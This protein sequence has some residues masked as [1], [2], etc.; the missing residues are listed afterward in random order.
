MV[1]KVQVFEVK[2]SPK[3]VKKGGGG[4]QGCRKPPNGFRGAIEG[5]WW[6]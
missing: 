5:F 6:I 4:N 3:V 2:T 1:V